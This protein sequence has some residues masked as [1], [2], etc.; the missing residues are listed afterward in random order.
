M[1]D[2][3]KTLTKEWAEHDKRLKEMEKRGMGGSYAFTA[4]M[5]AGPNPTEEEA[6]FWDNWKEDMK[7]RDY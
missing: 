1:E 4:L 6:A 2:D 7:M 3:E 5:M